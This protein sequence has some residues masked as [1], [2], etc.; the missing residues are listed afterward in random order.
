[1]F[2]EPSELRSVPVRPCRTK[3]VHCVRYISMFRLFLSTYDR[4]EP[5][6]TGVH[7]MNESTVHRLQ[8]STRTLFGTILSG[9]TLKLKIYLNRYAD[10]N[11]SWMVL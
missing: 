3:Q 7:Q 5:S 2:G 11:G 9:E 8:H 4:V 6:F 1:V 10:N